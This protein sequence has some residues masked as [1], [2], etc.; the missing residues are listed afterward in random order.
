VRGDPDPTDPALVCGSIALDTRQG[1]LDQSP[2][3]HPLILWHGSTGEHENQLTSTGAKRTKRGHRQRFVHHGGTSSL[4]N[5][6]W[7]T[8]NNTTAR[9][10]VVPFFFWTSCRAKRCDPMV[11]HWALHN[12]DS[13][14]KCETTFFCL[15]GGMTLLHPSFPPKKIPHPSL[16]ERESPDIR[17][18]KCTPVSQCHIQIA[19]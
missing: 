19:H 12:A 17:T 18:L 11:R 4:G 3:H 15:R 5:R 8:V 13:C 1:R 9:T 16:R 7:F 10:H 6:I 2:R 14:A